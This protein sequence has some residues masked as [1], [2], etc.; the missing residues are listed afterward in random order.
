MYIKCDTTPAKVQNIFTLFVFCFCLLYALVWLSIMKLNQS[1]DEESFFFC[2]CL[3]YNDGHVFLVGLPP[4]KQLSSD[5]HLVFMIVHRVCKNFRKKVCIC[6]S[7]FFILSGC[8]CHFNLNL[9][10]KEEK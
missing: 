8:C 1:L 9:Y 4:T 6:W 10:T 5:N 2:W 7:L 3:F